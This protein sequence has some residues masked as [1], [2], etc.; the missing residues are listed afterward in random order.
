MAPERSGSF[1]QSYDALHV[2]LWEGLVPP[3]DFTEQLEEHWKRGT[4]SPCIEMIRRVLIEGRALTHQ[5]IA[6][7]AG[8]SR[9]AVTRLVNDHDGGIDLIRRILDT[10]DLPF[11]SDPK[12]RIAGHCNAISYVRREVLKDGTGQRLLRP[13]EYVLL[14]YLLDSSAWV[15][16]LKAL[17]RARKAND[18]EL[19]SEGQQLLRRAA[20][21]IVQHA[22]DDVWQ[23]GLGG[24]LLKTEPGVTDLQGLVATWAEAYVLYLPEVNLDWVLPR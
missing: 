15:D 11:P 17:A 4:L 18:R 14:Y 10:F 20:A 21:A 13:D 3:E 1:H 12:C 19:L 16:A 23:H 6:D 22:R 8:C 7:K 24:S 5:A 2:A 9:A